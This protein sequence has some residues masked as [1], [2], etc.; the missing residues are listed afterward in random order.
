MERE[1]LESLINQGLS[2]RDIANLLRI[3]PTSVR[4][5][6]RKHNLKTQ[7][8]IS[9][10][11]RSVYK[12]GRCGENDPNKFY[13]HQRKVCAA[14]HSAYTLRLGQDKRLRAIK[15]AGGRCQVCGFDLYTCSLDFHHLDATVK[16]PKFHSLRGWSWERIMEE[17]QKCVLLC[18]N[19]HAAVHAGLLSV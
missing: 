19:Y 16:D 12:C 14:C 11:P 6:L 8:M 18:K 17:I 10:F 13:G 9:G 3:P 2:T 7:Y 15:E 5:R 4:R 1:L